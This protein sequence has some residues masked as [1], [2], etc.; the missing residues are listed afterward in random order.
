M[1][2]FVTASGGPTDAQWRGLEAN[3]EKLSANLAAALKP[4]VIGAQVGAALTKALKPL[5]NA[6]TA[7]AA[8]TSAHPRHQVAANA[9]TGGFKLPKA[10]D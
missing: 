5:V 7:D 10:E 4:E 8:P 2:T 3:V 9:K 1:K 6:S